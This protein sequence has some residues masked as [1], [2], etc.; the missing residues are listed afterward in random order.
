MEWVSHSYDYFLSI[1]PISTAMDYDQRQA[2]SPKIQAIESLGDIPSKDKE[3]IEE[4]I[5][6]SKLITWAVNNFAIDPQ[7]LRGGIDIEY[8]LYSDKGNNRAVYR[9]DIKKCSTKERVCSCMI[10]LSRF[11]DKSAVEHAILTEYVNPLIGHARPLTLR[12]DNERF[13]TAGSIVSGF[14]ADELIQIAPKLTIEAVINE[15]VRVWKLLSECFIYEPKGNQYIV[16]D[17]SIPYEAHLIDKGHFRFNQPLDC[18]YEVDSTT[19]EV[20]F[21]FLTNPRG[22]LQ[23]QDLFQP[24]RLSQLLLSIIDYSFLDYY[25]AHQS[26]SDGTFPPEVFAEVFPTENAFNAV[27]K[28]ELLSVEEKLACAKE[29][30]ELKR[31]STRAVQI[32]EEKLKQC[33]NDWISELNRSA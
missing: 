17:R 11:D 10:K 23:P 9:L 27:V 12:T 32:Y 22:V 26:Q 25:G 2:I 15:S 3:I 20:L 13:V 29:I 33:A 14:G 19:K 7:S 24:M 18:S 5:H 21:N 31:G 30:L 8:G 28:S 4:C 16:D 6:S 1:K